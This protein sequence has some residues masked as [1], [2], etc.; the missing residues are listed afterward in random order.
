[1]STASLL[2]RAKE[3]GILDAGAE[4]DDLRLA[5]D[6]GHPAAVDLLAGAGELLGRALA[7]SVNLLGPRLVIVIGEIAP[8]WPHLAEP[9]SQALAAHLPPCVRQTR[10][11]VRPWVD[12]LIAV[13]AAGIVLAAPLAAP[14]QKPRHKPR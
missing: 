3:Q 6:L 2:R 9:F 10:I 13:G 7:G 8:L 11:D 1:V 4:L 5:A 14:R 12:D